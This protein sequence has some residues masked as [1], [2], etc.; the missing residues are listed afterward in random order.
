MIEEDV[1][2]FGHL[3]KSWVVT[4]LKHIE[5]FDFG[6]WAI[7]NQLYLTVYHD[8]GWRSISVH[9]V[10]KIILKIFLNTLLMDLNA[11][12]FQ[13]TNLLFKVVVG[14]DM[15]ILLFEDVALIV[16][17]LSHIDYVLIKSLVPFQF[18][19]KV[20]YENVEYLFEFDLD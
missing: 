19:T 18:N 20:V 15:V 7:L 4:I 2:K 5:E 17:F 13:V 3:I 16:K 1:L 10:H 14:F 9:L 8:L 12:C 11:N 6:E